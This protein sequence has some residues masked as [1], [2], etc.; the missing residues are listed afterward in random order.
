[1]PFYYGFD[2]YYIILILPALLFGLWAQSQVNSSFNKYSRV[3]TM[4]GMTGA[5]AAEYI[6]N[7]NG[8][9]DVEVRHISGNL[10]DN[11]NP[12]NKTINLSDSVYNSTSI[13]AVGVAAHEAGHAVQ[14]AVNYKPIRIR[15]MII[16]VTQIGSWLYLPIILVGFIF[17]SQYLVNLGILLFSTLAIFQ[18]VTL[19]VEFNASNRAIATL[20]GSGILYGEEI[21]G[22]KKVL[23]AAA[24]TYV[25]ALVSSLAQLLRLVLIFGGRRKD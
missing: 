4:R 9:Y 13:A 20:E 16:P 1:M 11:F 8:I 10:T 25:A 17:S 22:A 3:G 19:P 23:R 6:L 5:Q 21:T 12:K 7:Q 14:H 15:E 24:L 18:L 2:I